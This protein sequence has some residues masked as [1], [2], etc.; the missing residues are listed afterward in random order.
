MK[1]KGY[2]KL[3][4]Q[5]LTYVKPHKTA[6]FLSVIFD[7][8][9]IGLNMAVPI[10]SGL[11]IECLV[12]VGQVNFHL[13]FEYFVCF[14]RCVNQLSVLYRLFFCFGYQFYYGVSGS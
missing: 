5:L 2:S 12:G 1:K 11:S 14:S 10:F 8:L 9:A 6:F 7:L 3:L 4:A 13:L